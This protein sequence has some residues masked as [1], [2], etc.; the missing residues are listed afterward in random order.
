MIDLGT[1]PGGN[2]SFAMDINDRGII[3][4]FSNGE[5]VPTGVNGT[6]WTNRRRP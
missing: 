1:L 5:E 2:T 4:G 3:A 6:I